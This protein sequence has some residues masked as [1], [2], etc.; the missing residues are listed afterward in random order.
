MPLSDSRPDPSAVP[1]A[2]LH[3]NT[4]APYQKTLA[5]GGH[6]NDY[7]VE[8]EALNTVQDNSSIVGM[9]M[10]GIHPAIAAN[11]LANPLPRHA[12]RPVK[13]PA[14]VDSQG[15]PVWR[16]PFK[17]HS[18]DTVIEGIEALKIRNQRELKGVVERR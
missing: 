6:I 9:A 15:K 11:I 8:G 7:I 17:R 3:P 4:I 1:L 14:N 18:I 5:D 13:V 16:D 2:G 10:V 12:G